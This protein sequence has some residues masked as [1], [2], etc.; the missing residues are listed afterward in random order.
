MV[1]V[2]QR[3]HCGRRSYGLVFTAR[4]APSKGRLLRSAHLRIQEIVG[5][6]H[7][8]HGIQHR[9][10]V[11]GERAG[12]AGYTDAAVGFTDVGLKFRPGEWPIHGKPVQ[13]SEAQIFFREAVDV[14]LPVHGGAAHGHGSRDDA[15]T[16]LIFDPIARPGVLTVEDGAFA[17]GHALFNIEEALPCLDD[18]NVQPRFELRKLCARKAADIPP[19]MMQR[20][21]SMRGTGL[22]RYVSK[23]LFRFVRHRAVAGHDDLTAFHDRLDTVH[24]D[25]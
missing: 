14:P 4:G 23:C 21:L 1:H 3:R 5:E 7:G 20:S 22:L 9:L 8:G 16:G 2:P 17:I 18:H 6:R 15:F 11:F 12:V 25:L 13:G 19:P 24:D 10:L